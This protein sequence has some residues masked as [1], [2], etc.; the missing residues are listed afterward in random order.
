MDNN[1]S[2]ALIT[3]NSGITVSNSMEIDFEEDEEADNYENGEQD[4][5]TSIACPSTVGHYQQNNL[6]NSFQS[7]NNVN[8]VEDD[9]DDE[10]EDE[11]EIESEMKSNFF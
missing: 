6:V 9:E 2:S 11:E 7:L 8:N 3:L 4:Y 10:Y 1:D 5:A